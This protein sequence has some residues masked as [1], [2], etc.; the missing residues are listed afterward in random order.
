[1]G[2]GVGLGWVWG[3]FERLWGWG[4]VW[5]GFGGGLRGCGVVG[6]FGVGLG[7]V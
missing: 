1:M 5:G 4:L 6:W 7:V 2:L 3:W